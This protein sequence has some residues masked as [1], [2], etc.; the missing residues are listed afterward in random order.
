LTE[1]IELEQER[2]TEALQMQNRLIQAQIDLMK[3]RAAALERGGAIISIDGAGLQPHLEA[4]MWE[5]LRT[6]QTR[7]NNDGL[8]MLLGV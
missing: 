2:R 5:I 4:F 1:A 3:A 8:E 6:I 7:V